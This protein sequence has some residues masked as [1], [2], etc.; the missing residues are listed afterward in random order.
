V[1]ETDI[2]RVR[3]CR[4]DDHARAAIVPVID[5]MRQ[6]GI[7]VLARGAIE[8]YY[9][10]N[11]PLSGSKP[12]RALAA[13]RLVTDRASALGLSQ[14]LGPGRDPELLEICRALFRGL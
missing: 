11:S 14:S 13:C 1:A 9:P 10:A 2:A 4:E 8:D 7:C 12:E 5:V 6:A 3:V